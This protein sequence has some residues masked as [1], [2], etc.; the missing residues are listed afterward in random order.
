MKTIIYHNPRCSKSRKAL[1]LLND[2]NID[3]VIIEYLKQPLDQKQ[4]IKLLSE[5]GLSAREIMRHKEEAYKTNNLNNSHL[6]E[7]DLIQAIIK[8][9]ILLERPIVVHKN[10]AKI[11]RPP[12][13]VLKLIS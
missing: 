3:I 13:L 11:C 5:L 10:K 6:T 12:E 1:E 2:N 9:P 7:N 8:N 4:I